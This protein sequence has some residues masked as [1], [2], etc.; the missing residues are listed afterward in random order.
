MA[1]RFSLSTKECTWAE[2]H[3]LLKFKLKYSSE[4]NRKNFN[5]SCNV[6]AGA[7]AAAAG[8]RGDGN[9]GEDDQIAS[10]SGD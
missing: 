5:D 9:A 2:R 10:V 4:I 6:F 7:P 8:T 3:V 1:T